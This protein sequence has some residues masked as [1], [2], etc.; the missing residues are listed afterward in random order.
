MASIL[1]LLEV[2]AKPQLREASPPPPLKTTFSA[3]YDFSRFYKQPTI[4]LL[5]GALVGGRGWAWPGTLESIPRMVEF[6]QG[7]IA[8]LPSFA[9]DDAG[10]RGRP[11]KALDHQTAPRRPPPPTGDRSCL[12]S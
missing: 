2:K 4:H 1:N 10:E 9:T 5:Q 11:Q 8:S 6:G 12:I 7:L 3:Y